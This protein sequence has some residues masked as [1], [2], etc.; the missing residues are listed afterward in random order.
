MST[1]PS[2][3][4]GIIDALRGYF[5]TWIGLYNTFAVFNAIRPN[6]VLS[7]ILLFINDKGWFCLSAIFGYG[8]GVLIKRSNQESKHFIKR[9]LILFG[10]GL[11][12]NLFYYGDILKEYAVIGLILFFTQRISKKFPVIFIA[13]LLMFVI[14]GLYFIPF[15]MQDAGDLKVY[16][17][18]NNLFLA[19]LKYCF[20]LN[21]Q[22][23]YFGICYHLEMLFLASIGYM[24]AFYQIETLIVRYRKVL[25][26]GSLF[27]MVHSLL[28]IFFVLDNQ[29]SI[30]KI[31]F[32]VY[33]LSLSIFFIVGF[34]YLSKKF[35]K[36]NSFFISFGRRS[37]TIYLLQ[38]FLICT[39]WALSEKTIVLQFQTLF[40]VYCIGQIL[41]LVLS[42]SLTK[43]GIGVVEFYWRAW[44]LKE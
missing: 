36:F 40:I 2:Q 34:Y 31:A 27:T 38:N 16:F 5:I 15:D 3:R 11:F 21:T 4:K 26:H 28:L 44:S 1:V 17:K 42:K 24:I 32:F 41:I 20:S 37:L 18:D 8:F 33:I 43:Q 7:S 29:N 6:L 23:L 22:S 10:L 19:N 25:F 12:N 30:I 13:S 9:M 39:I 35:K 14:L